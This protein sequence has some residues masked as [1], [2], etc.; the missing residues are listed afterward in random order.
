MQ[1]HMRGILQVYYTAQLEFSDDGLVLLTYIDYF[2]IIFIIF[3]VLNV[4]ERRIR[5]WRTFYTNCSNSYK[6]YNN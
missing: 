2:Y 5:I 3:F 1:Y 4:Y 6:Q